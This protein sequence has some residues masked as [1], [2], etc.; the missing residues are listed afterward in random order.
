MAIG[1]GGVGMLTGIGFGGVGGVTFGRIILGSATLTS[2]GGGIGFGGTSL[3]FGGSG[4][5]TATGTT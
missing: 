1:F 4:G 5:L 3:G 2:G